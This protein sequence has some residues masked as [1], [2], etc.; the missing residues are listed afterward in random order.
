MYNSV[1][2][3]MQL[4]KEFEASLNKVENISSDLKIRNQVFLKKIKHL[5]DV[6]F[7][8]ERK[9]TILQE[10]YNDSNLDQSQINKMILATQK[11][12]KEFFESF[13]QLETMQNL[14]KSLD[15]VYNS[16]NIKSLQNL[17]EN[18]NN[19]EE[20]INNEN[21]DKNS[22]NENDQQIQ[23]GLRQSLFN[24]FSEIRN[25]AISKILKTLSK[26]FEQIDENVLTLPNYE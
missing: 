25:I 10:I 7:D 8:L 11:L 3:L 5:K 26:S 22:D 15:K 23:D 4:N 6:E 12:D 2:S 9:K 13:A 14:Y 1:K 21:D 16:Q 18:F 24:N 19:Q 20:N 17:E